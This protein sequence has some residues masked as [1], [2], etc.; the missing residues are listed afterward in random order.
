MK[1]TEKSSELSMLLDCIAEQSPMQGRY[2][3]DLSEH[4][5]GEEFE[6]CELLLQFYKLQGESIHSLTEAY[7]MFCNDT[8]EETKY[9]M[10][11]DD[12]RYHKFSDVASNV[13][14]DEAYMRKY[15]IGLGLS[16][17]FW[18]QHRDCVRFF[19]DA[20]KKY[21][22]VG[23]AFLQIGPGHGKYFCDAARLGRCTKYT[24]VDVSE[25]S[26]SMTQNLLKYFLTTERLDQCVFECSDITKET[27]GQNYDF[28]TMCEVLEHV[29]QPMSLLQSLR[30]MS[31]RGGHVFIS[32]PVNAPEKDHIYLFRNIDDVVNMVHDAGFSVVEQQCF[33]TR[34]RT[35]EKALKYKD[36]ILV[37]MV[38]A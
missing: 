28:I 25:T 8:M 36:A 30:R 13:Y 2:L 21:A 17:F 12:Y 29:E 3:T 34:R 27:S 32:V 38:L 18:P 37:A 35:L 4:L 10:E 31:T 7:L 16:L 33:F 20:Y 15:M 26:L 22:P 19:S 9:F 11:H 23:G 1:N 5:T 6:D 24:A 14:Y